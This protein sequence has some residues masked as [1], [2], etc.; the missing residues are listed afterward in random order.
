MTDHNSPAPQFPGRLC[1]ICLSVI[2]PT[3]DGDYARRTPYT[4]CPG[5]CGTCYG[6]DE[7]DALALV[8]A[9]PQGAASQGDAPRVTWEYCIEA[10][11]DMSDLGAEGWLL[12]GVGPD[13]IGPDG[14]GRGNAFAIYARPCQG[15]GRGPR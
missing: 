4:V 1:R 13:A 11:V 9:A 2:P 10:L 3:R 7:Y 6:W 12:V 5:P 14:C 8:D 15:A